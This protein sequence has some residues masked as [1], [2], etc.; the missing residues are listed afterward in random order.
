[1]T[2]PKSDITSKPGSSGWHLA[3]ERASSGKPYLGDPAVVGALIRGLVAGVLNRY[4]E[5]TEGRLDPLQASASDRAE[6]ERLGR[7][8][9]GL[10]DHYSAVGSW[11]GKGLADAV[12]REM[13]GMLADDADSD[14][15]AAITQSVAVVVH[16][17]YEALRRMPV[18]ESPTEEDKAALQSIVDYASRLMAGVLE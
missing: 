2:D 3:L 13:A 18:S 15:V 4:A 17:V 8:F 1:M 6:C 9:A 14:D 5:V 10:D 7:V 16:R 11:N 12:R